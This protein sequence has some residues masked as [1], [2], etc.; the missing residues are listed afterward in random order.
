[1]KKGPEY[2][3]LSF[4]GG[5]NNCCTLYVTCVGLNNVSFTLDI[6]CIKAKQSVSQMETLTG[7]DLTQSSAAN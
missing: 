3:F 4:F 1:M 7:G 2:L 5:V 6:G